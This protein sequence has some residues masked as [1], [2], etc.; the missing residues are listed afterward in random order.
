MS[1]TDQ[2]PEKTQGI[3]EQF[4]DAVWMEQGLSKNTLAAYR[5]D[6][7]GFAL[8]LQQQ[9]RD[10]NAADESEI[11]GYLAWRFHQGTRNRSAARMLSS[12]QSRFGSLREALKAYGPK[13]VGYYYADK[14]LAIYDRY[15][16]K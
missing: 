3:I 11:Q 16:G 7:S 15:Q 10:I 2:L 9:H 8:W 14:V 5:N 6:L 4:I 12:L 1:K 13:D